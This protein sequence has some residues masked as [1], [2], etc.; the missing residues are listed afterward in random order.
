V[1]EQVRAVR[2]EVQAGD[3]RAVEEVRLPGQRPVPGDVDGVL[4]AGRQ[5]RSRSF[6]QAQ[7]AGMEELRS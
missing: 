7:V 2:L 6:D 1:Q 5:G 4:F 3:D